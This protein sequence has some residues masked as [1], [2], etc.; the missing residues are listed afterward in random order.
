MKFFWLSFWLLQAEDDI[1]SEAPSQMFM[2][3]LYLPLYA[4]IIFAICWQFVY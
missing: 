4:L 3:V 2:R 1:T